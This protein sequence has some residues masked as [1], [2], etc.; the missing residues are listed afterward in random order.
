MIS[1]YLRVASQ[2]PSRFTKYCNLTAAMISSI[3]VCLLLAR[4]PGLTGPRVPS[5]RAAIKE[6][7]VKSAVMPFLGAF[8]WYV[9]RKER[10]EEEKRGEQR[11][12]AARRAE[13]MRAEER[14]EEEEMTSLGDKEECSGTSAPYSTLDAC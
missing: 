12:G 9:K 10:R 14:S 1:T 8:V 7:G 11:R 4:Y 3:P 13:N 6:G 5:I 2:P